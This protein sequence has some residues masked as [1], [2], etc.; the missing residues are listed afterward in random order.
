MLYARR[1]CSGIGWRGEVA[2]DAELL[3]QCKKLKGGRGKIDVEGAGLYA[4]MREQARK[5]RCSLE[6]IK[7]NIRIFNTFCQ[8]QVTHYLRLDDKGFYHAAL[9]A[10][11]PL[12]AIEFFAKE[13]Q[14]NELFT[15]AEA[16]R[17]STAQREKRNAS[18]NKLDAKLSPEDKSMTAFLRR[19]IQEIKDMQARCPDKDFA[20]RVFPSMVDDLEDQFA[21]IADGNSENLCRMA[22][23][24]GH[25]RE[26]QMVAFT[27]L[28]RH[29]VSVTMNRLS[30]AQ[31]FWEVEEHTH[32]RHDKRWQ[33]AGVPLVGD[34]SARKVG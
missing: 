11:N 21:T 26:Q 33:K 16:R 4:A 31:E 28:S 1:Q 2:C 17:W 7:L 29:N 34:L 27:G 18:A 19:S 25:Y 20:R 32:G 6:T 24:R 15:V 3:T 22:W 12:K 30:E 8:T 23:E 5:T 13:F 14:S 10:P 9:R